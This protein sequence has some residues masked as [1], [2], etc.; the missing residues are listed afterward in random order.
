[1]LALETKCDRQIE[2][3]IADI[4][5]PGGRKLAEQFQIRYIPA[6]LFFNRAGEQ[7]AQRVGRVSSQQ[8][9]EDILRV[10]KK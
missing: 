5:S 10:I 9:E 3:I 2:F 8:L 4:D 6:F 7:A 1:M